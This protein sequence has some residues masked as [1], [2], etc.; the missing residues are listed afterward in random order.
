MTQCIFQSDFDRPCEEEAVT[1]DDLCIFHDPSLEK[2]PAKIQ[3]RLKARLAATAKDGVLRLDG[4]VFPAGVSFRGAVF[5][6][7]VSFF[8]VRFYGET[9]DFSFT[10]FRGGID[11]MFALFHGKSTDFRAA[12]FRGKSTDF[13]RAQ[14]HGET[15]DFESAHFHGETTYFETAEFNCETTNFIGAR[16]DG[17]T[18]DFN[19]AEF[20]GK[21]DFNGAEFHGKTDFSLAKFRDATDFFGAKFH[22]ATTNFSFAEFHGAM[23][24]F[25]YAQFHGKVLFYGSLPE[26]MFHNGAVSFRGIVM[27]EN[28]ELVFEGVNLSKTELLQVDLARVKFLDVEWN[29]ATGWWRGRWRSR[30]YDEELWQKER[31]A[32]ALE[33]NSEYLAHLARLYRALKAYYRQTGEYQ[34]VGHFHYGLMEVQWHQRELKDQPPYG[35]SRGNRFRHWLKRKSRKWLSWEA[36]YRLS[37]GYGEDYAWSALMLGGLIVGFAAIYWCLGVPAPP[38]TEVSRWVSLSAPAV[39]GL[40]HVSLGAPAALVH[41]PFWSNMLAALLF[42]LQ[43][44]SIGR[45]HYFNDPAAMSPWADLVYTLESILGPVQIAFFAVALRNRFRR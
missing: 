23:T 45:L 10:Q 24:D 25:R 28:A 6:C 32:V 4:S 40:Q 12:Q 8:R 7:S 5:D 15:T 26:G 11:F 39:E 38:D 33:A 44:A 35:A 9:T 29:H 13:R 17:K 41:K 16:F 43:T 22:G 31:R 14:F 2:D 42:S 20:H 18:T 1:S 30:L 3:E 34:L 36:M 37:S 21:T 27:S 19:S